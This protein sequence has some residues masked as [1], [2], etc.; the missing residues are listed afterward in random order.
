MFDIWENNPHRQ[1]LTENDDLSN[2]FDIIIIR[3]TF[4]NL[5]S[6]IMADRKISG[7]TF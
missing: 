1:Y 6:Y 7:L 4:Y 2:D 5:Y 3:E